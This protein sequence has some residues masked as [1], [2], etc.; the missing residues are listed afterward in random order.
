MQLYIDFLH[1]SVSHFLDFNKKKFTNFILDF[2]LFYLFK[3]TVMYNIHTKYSKFIPH[4]G[5]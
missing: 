4:V 1:V 5:T 2:F 3:N